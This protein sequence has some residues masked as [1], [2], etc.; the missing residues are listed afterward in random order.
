MC[1]S[2]SR[3]CLVFL[4][5]SASASLHCAPFVADFSGPALDP[6][7]SWSIDPGWS[8]TSGSGRAIFASNGFATGSPATTG[9][10][11]VRATYTTLIPG[12]FSA[13]VDVDLSKTSNVVAQLIFKVQGMNDPAFYTNISGY[14]SI[15][16]TTGAN[17]GG[18]DPLTLAFPPNAFGVPGS[19]TLRMTRTGNIITQFYKDQSA[20]DFIQFH[21]FDAPLWDGLGGYVALTGRQNQAALSPVA[22]PF[23]QFRVDYA[24][25][26]PVPETGLL[27][28]FGLLLALATRRHQT[29]NRI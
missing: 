16:Q 11:R 7:L 22:I 9:S 24:A 12:D 26:V 6:A 27:V 21:T 25:T 14:K 19:M 23:S 8:V 13:Q 2:I 29:R 3:L 20:A 10:P 5:G 18:W 15:N 17:I 28:G 1:S 4:L